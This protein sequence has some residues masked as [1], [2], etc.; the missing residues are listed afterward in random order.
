M[1]DSIP[2]CIKLLDTEDKFGC[3]KSSLGNRGYVLYLC[4]YLFIYLCIYL[5]FKIESEY[6]SWPKFQKQSL[7]RLK[8]SDLSAVF[9]MGIKLF[10]GIS[11]RKIQMNSEKQVLVLLCYSRSM[12][13]GF[14]SEQVSVLMLAIKAQSRLAS[15]TFKAWDTVCLFLFLRL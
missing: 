10:T 5:F 3:T 12:H 14:I 6:K 13:G 11:S 15:A 9:P 4:I 8:G 1:L 7:F 2:F